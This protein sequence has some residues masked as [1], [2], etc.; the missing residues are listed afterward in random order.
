MLT[1]SIHT[2]NAAFEANR[3]EECATI[4]R[5]IAAKLQAGHT[6]GDCLDA[7][8][9]TVGCWSLAKGKE[10]AYLAFGRVGEIVCNERTTA[11]RLRR[12]IGGERLDAWLTMCETTGQ[13]GA[14]EE[15]GDDHVVFTGEDY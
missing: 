2:G 6:D 8:G 3:G 11:K 15:F 9:N 14:C 4:L 13:V 5:E 12:R 1:I 7:N 10:L